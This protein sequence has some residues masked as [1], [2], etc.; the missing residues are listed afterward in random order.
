MWNGQSL[1]SEQNTVS[2]FLPRKFI[3]TRILCHRREDRMI[4]H[5]SSLIS[6]V[7]NLKSARS[8]QYW[9]NRIMK[10]NKRI[11]CD[12]VMFAHAQLRDLMVAKF[13]IYFNKMESHA[14]DFLV[15]FI[16]NSNFSKRECD[17]CPSIIDTLFCFRVLQQWSFGLE[18]LSIPGFFTRIFHNIS[19]FVNIINACFNSSI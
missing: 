15:E 8:L 14:K 3:T 16:F 11:L 12:S 17:S 18:A 6:G 4:H 13:C 7:L 10:R 5:Q 1:M 9:K 19:T 2:G